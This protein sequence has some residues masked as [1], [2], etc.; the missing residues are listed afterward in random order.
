MTYELMLGSSASKR[1][2]LVCYTNGN[3]PFKIKVFIILSHSYRTC[4]DHPADLPCRHQLANIS[5]SHL[6]I[7]NESSV[8]L[9]SPLARSLLHGGGPWHPVGLHGPD[10]VTSIPSLR[11]GG[12]ARALKWSHAYDGN[13]VSYINVL[14][15]WTAR[16][17]TQRRSIERGGEFS[18][19]PRRLGAP[20]SLKNTEKG[21]SDGCFLTSYMHKIHFRLG[22]SPRPH[23]G[24]L[25]CSPEP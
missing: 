16:L 12:F 4:S 21:V 23:W 17:F 15:H 1:I 6:T 25:R 24:T 7:M 19:A 20:P 11:A 22:L 9:S 3:K 2:G 10:G 8:C 18:R 13:V 14:N 5:A